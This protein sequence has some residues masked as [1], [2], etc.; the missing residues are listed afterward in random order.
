MTN[1]TY[2]D[3]FDLIESLAGVDEFAPTE[4]TKILAM[5]HRRWRQA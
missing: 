2:A 3:L 1:R 4:S 5:A